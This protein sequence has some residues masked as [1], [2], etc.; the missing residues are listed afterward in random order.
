MQRR[1]FLQCVLTAS[2]ATVVAPQVWAE[3]RS[4]VQFYD[5]EDIVNPWGVDDEIANLIPQIRADF[6]RALGKSIDRAILEMHAA[7]WA[8]REEND[9]A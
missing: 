5:V 8:R 7:G 4:V 1:N 3:Q 6:A 2:A 9:A